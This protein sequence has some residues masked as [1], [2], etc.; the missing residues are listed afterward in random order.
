MQ[1]GNSCMYDTWK[2]LQRIVVVIVVVVVVVVVVVSIISYDKI[3]ELPPS[4]QPIFAS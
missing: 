3:Q 4:K 1:I 2:S